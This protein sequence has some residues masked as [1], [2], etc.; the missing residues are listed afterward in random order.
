MNHKVTEKLNRQLDLK[1][2]GPQL[3]V[4]LVSGYELHS[5]GVNTISCLINPVNNGTK[6][7]L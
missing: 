7:D 6:H 5:L 2:G 3:C 1:G 4:L